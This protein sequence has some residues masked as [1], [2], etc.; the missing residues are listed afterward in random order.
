VYHKTI[1]LKTFA[2]LAKK[3]FHLSV[4]FDIG[5][6]ELPEKVQQKKRNEKKRSQ[7]T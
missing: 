3:V 1:N 4:C 5:K 2:P 7:F 6:K